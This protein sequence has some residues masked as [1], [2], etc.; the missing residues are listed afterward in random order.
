[1]ENLI[2][3][4][5]DSTHYFLLDCKQGK[6]LV[7]AGMPGSLPKFMGQLRNYSV[8]IR[9]IRNVMMTHSHPDHAGILQEIKRAAGAKLI[10]HEQQVPYLAEL[11][12]FCGKKGGI[13]L[14]IE[15]GDLVV[16]DENRPVFQSLGL[17]GEMVATPGH[18]NDSYT[19]VTDGG[20]AFVGD[21]NPLYSVYEGD[22]EIMIES[23][24]KLVRMNAKIF[25][26]SHA[27]PVTVEEIKKLIPI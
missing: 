9:D 26:P 24:R 16:N 22:E 5:Y 10:I 2:T 13:P 23:W 20:M 11:R 25:Y 18:S 8:N 12:A 15:N 6:L 4:T 1:M 7:D 3:L 19:L 14:E 21:L 27:N 17:R